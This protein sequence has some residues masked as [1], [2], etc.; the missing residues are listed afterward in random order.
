M[1]PKSTKRPASK[2]IR[3]LTIYCET[4]FVD[5]IERHGKEEGRKLS[6]M[7]RRLIEEALAAR[8]ARVGAK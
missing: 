8:D 3:P 4:S 2:S 5:R 6:P 1:K 7:A